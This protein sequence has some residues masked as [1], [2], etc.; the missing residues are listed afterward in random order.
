MELENNKGTWKMNSERICN[1]YQLDKNEFKNLKKKE[2][3]D[4]I[5]KFETA[6]WK[7]EMTKKKTLELYRKYKSQIKQEEDYYNDNKSKIWFQVKTNCL[8]F[9]K[10]NENNKCKICKEGNEDLNHFI[11]Y[12]NKLSEI[13]KQH[14]AFQRPHIENEN[15]LLSNII[16]KNEDKEGIKAIVEKMWIKRLTLLKEE[17]NKQQWIQAINTYGTYMTAEHNLY[18]ACKNKKILQQIIAV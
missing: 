10:K 5:R 12:C 4:K 8:F 16:Y 17:E 3:T 2:L 9:K 15:E 11:L 14:D 7:E 1:K 6:S 18:K 13:R